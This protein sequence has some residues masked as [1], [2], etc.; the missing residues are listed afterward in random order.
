MNF[1]IGSGLAALTEVGNEAED[2]HFFGG[3]Y[4]ILTDKTSPAWQYTLIDST[5]DG[6]REAAIREHEA[7]L[8]LIRD[9]F[10]NVPTAIDIDPRYSDELWVKDCDFKNVSGQAVTISDEKSPMTEIG[11]EN[12]VLDNV[13]VFA[14]FR[15]SGKTVEGMGRTY[16]VSNFN[17]GVIVASEGAM[18]MIRPIYK[19][20][21]LASM[22]PALPH[23]IPALP[24]T[25]E[26]VNVHTLGVK[27]DGETDDTAA[28]QK[29][30]DAH[31]V[32]YFP[33]GHYLVKDTLNLKPDTVCDRA[34]PDD[35]AVCSAGWDSGLSG[36]GRAEGVDL[37]AGGRDEHGERVRHFYR[38][39]QCAGC[40]A[41]VEGGRGF[42]GGRYSLSG[43]AWQRSEPLQPRPHGRSRSAQAMG[44]AVSEPVGCRWRGRNLRRYLDAE[45]VCAVRILRLK[46]E[47]AGARV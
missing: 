47:D 20:D 14:R 30:I 33:S 44:R 25:T 38:R 3:R 31:R 1:H 29:A 40:G 42:A 45:H 39:N 7:A 16:Q 17:Y 6:Q 11:F 8:T 27:G 12:A 9:S 28:I 22:P 15:E 23:A 18:G 36:R 35:D 4:G 26:W 43:R 2:L 19:V 46:H 41:A 5:F 32:L 10:S 24:P 37:S 34:A 13:P 21:A